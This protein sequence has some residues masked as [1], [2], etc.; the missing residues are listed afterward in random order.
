MKCVKEIRTGEDD[1]LRGDSKAQVIRV[2]NAEAD[3]LVTNGIYQYASKEEW[4]IHGRKRP[5]NVA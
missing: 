1:V 4:K 2:T 3:L 5:N